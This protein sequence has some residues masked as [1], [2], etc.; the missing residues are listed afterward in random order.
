MGSTVKVNICIMCIWPCEHKTH[1]SLSPITFKLQM[2]VVHDERR[3]SIDFG[4]KVKV[5]LSIV[6]KTFGHYRL[7]YFSNHFPTSHVSCRSWE[8][9][10][11]WFWVKGQ[12]Q[13]WR[14]VYK[15][16]WVDTDYSFLHISCWWWE[17]E[18]YLLI[19]GHWIKAQGQ[20]W[21]FVCKTLWA[22]YRLQLLP[23]HFQP[24][25]VSCWWWEEESINFQSR[26]QML[27]SSLSLSEGMS[28]FVFSS[29]FS[30]TY[31]VQNL[32]FQC[33]RDQMLTEF[34]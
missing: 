21:H 5:N 6:Y 24:S 30:F 20:L 34:T 27:R 3:N 11:Y 1:Y 33:C 31:K 29:A 10:P 32:K 13:L 14:C 23:D 28:C 25:H 4:S 15:T 2:S 22:G 19:L 18:P 7:Q 16:L 17:E 9:E 26:G 12:G 8:E